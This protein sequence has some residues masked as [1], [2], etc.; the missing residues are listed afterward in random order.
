[1]NQ[2]K[3]KYLVNK[4]EITK[5]RFLFLLLIAFGLIA[6]CDNNS[7]SMD[8]ELIVFNADI[9]TVDQSQNRAEA[10]AIKDGRFVAVGNNDE[11]LELK[12]ATTESINANGDNHSPRLHR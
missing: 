8:P 1:M 11:V 9:R 5:L 10:F 2:E 3:R 7:P 12:G 4:A 6:S